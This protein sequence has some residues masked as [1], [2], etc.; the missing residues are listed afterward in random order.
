MENAKRKTVKTSVLTRIEG[1]GPAKA[2]KLLA[3][4]GGMGALRKATLEE[5]G[6]VRGISLHDA[7]AVW[8]DLH[9]TKQE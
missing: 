1:I 6:A 8:R 5:I 3:A 4:F 2:K 9:P 7:E